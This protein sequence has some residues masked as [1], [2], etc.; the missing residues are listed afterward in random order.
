MRRASPL[1]ALAL[2]GCV[3]ERGALT[4]PPGDA[5]AV[6]V[7]APQPDARS[8]VDAPARA[9]DAAVPTDTGCNG[10]DEDGDG[11][12]GTC[13]PWPCGPTAPSLEGNVAGQGITLSE[14][15]LNGGGATLVVRGG[16]TVSVRTRFRIVDDDCTGCI[17]QIEI[18]AVPGG[19]QG[20]IY[21]ADPPGGGA[22]GEESIDVAMPEVRAPMRVDLR[23]NRRHDYNCGRD[24]WVAEPGPSR[25][26]GVVCVVP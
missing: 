16:S 17:K 2:A 8:A 20:C 13:D 10:P 22:T 5:N 24:W 26:F 6:G 15:R 21:S 9:E 25:T 3:I 14:I 19:F 1:L 23:F 7:D 12:L 18:G 4:A 11:L